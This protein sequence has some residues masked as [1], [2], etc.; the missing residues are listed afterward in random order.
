MNLDATVANLSRAAAQKIYGRRET[1]LGKPTVVFYTQSEAELL[2]KESIHIELKKLG[3][4][5]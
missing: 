1:T 4:V 3:L 5:K 2:I